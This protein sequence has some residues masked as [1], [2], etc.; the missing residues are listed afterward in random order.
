MLPAETSG[1]G[2]RWPVVVVSALLAAAALTFVS[3]FNLAGLA[4]ALVLAGL[5]VSRTGHGE[6]F[7]AWVTSVGVGVMAPALPMTVLRGMD[8]L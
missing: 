7:A 5:F 4:A 6:Y 1:T 3:P 2:L 8:S